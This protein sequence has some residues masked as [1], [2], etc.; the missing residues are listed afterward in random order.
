VS[1]LLRQPRGFEGF[2]AA[3]AWINLLEMG[4]RK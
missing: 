4:S 3:T 2:G 1:V